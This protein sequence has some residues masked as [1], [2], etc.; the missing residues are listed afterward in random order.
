[1]LLY[2]VF[3]VVFNDVVVKYQTRMLSF[4]SVGNKVQFYLSV[5][6]YKLGHRTNHRRFTSSQSGKIS[7]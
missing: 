5:T 6:R 4:V 2:Q 7:T 1:M 3:N